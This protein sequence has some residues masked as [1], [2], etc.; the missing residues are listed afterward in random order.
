M[1]RPLRPSPRSRT[2]AALLLPALALG[3]G[4]CESLRGEPS[5][6]AHGRHVATV[7]GFLEPE[8]AKYDAAQDAWFVSSIVGYGSGRDNDAYISRV[9]GAGFERNEVFVR[10]GRN[11][12]ELHAP[13]GM[14]LQGDT[15]WVADIDVLRGFHRLTGA[16]VANVD[17]SPFRA[18]MLNGV[19]LGPAGEVIITDTGIHMTDKG[20]V[21]AEGSRIFAMGPGRT[22]RVLAEGEWLIHPNGIA[23]EPGDGR[24]VVASFNA[25]VSE[26][27]AL[28]PG[29]TTRTT[30][31][32]GPGRY[33]GLTRIGEGQYLTTSWPD[34]AVY[35]IEGDRTRRIGGSIWTPADIGYDARR[36]I[37]AV[38]S[39]LMGRVE[40]WELP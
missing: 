22:V 5:V 26:V 33:D 14:V 6:P 21:F 15:L 34:S 16:P 3:S 8:S 25:H 29:D 40:F 10:S 27:Y 38:P 18:V 28:R 1:S 36:R 17:F 2:A 20:V 7:Q 39:V 31:V 9:D 30:I 24:F 19:T 4:G 37:V 13:K 35:L 32:K 23:W 12:V 11:G